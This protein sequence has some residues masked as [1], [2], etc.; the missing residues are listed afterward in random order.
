MTFSS[1]ARKTRVLFA[2]TDLLLT[3]VA[4]EAAYFTRLGL[5][6]EHN[7]AIPEYSLVLGFCCLIW[8]AAGVW[9]GVHDR[10][11][12]VDWRVILRD[13]FRQAMLGTLGLL[14]FEF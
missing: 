1:Q 10:L 5:Q 6:L 4:F 2:T 8:V 13:G 7:F 3:A 14:I 12:G 11:G 9:L